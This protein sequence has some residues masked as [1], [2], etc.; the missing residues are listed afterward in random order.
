MPHW[1]EAILQCIHICE[2][3]ASL[4]Q[5]YEMIPEHVDLTPHLLKKTTRSKHPAYHH[6]VRNRI[7]NLCTAGDVQRISTGQYRLTPK[8]LERLD[9]V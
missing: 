2:G 4:S 9:P 5:I 1:E 7:R 8:G 6:W 3:E